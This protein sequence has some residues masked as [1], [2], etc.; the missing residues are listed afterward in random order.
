LA[1]SL[2]AIGL[3]VFLELSDPAYGKINRLV[4]ELRKSWLPTVSI[5]VTLFFLIVAFKI[6]VILA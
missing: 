5:L 2:I 3:L 6:Y 4:F 1:V